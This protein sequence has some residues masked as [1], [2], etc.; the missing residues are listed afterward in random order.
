ME[1]Q[2]EEYFH[3]ID[4]LGGVIPA[5]E[6]GF[7]QREIADAA[8]R[9]QQAL[10]RGDQ[11]IVGVN[12]FVE[13]NSKPDIPVLTIPP[14]VES[15]QARRLARVRTERDAAAAEATLNTLKHAAESGSN[16]LP[17]LLACTRAYV[18]LGEMC[19]TLAGVFG[20]YDEAATF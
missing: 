6:E 9:Y 13:E 14:E 7:F 5:I 10:D 4:D 11:S 8:Y 18:T 15:Q 1:E 20:L 2:A 19:S 12:R 17:P 3:R 16:I